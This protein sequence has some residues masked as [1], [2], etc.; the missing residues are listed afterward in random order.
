VNFE[1]V[2]PRETLLF[3]EFAERKKNNKKIEKITL[4]NFSFL[5]VWMGE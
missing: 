2:S 1:N 3:F 4:S 5:W